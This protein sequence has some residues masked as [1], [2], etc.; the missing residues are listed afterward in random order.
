MAKPRKSLKQVKAVPNSDVVETP[1][2]EELSAVVTETKTDTNT[3]TDDALDQE[4]VD[5]IRRQSNL[6]LYGKEE[7]SEYDRILVRLKERSQ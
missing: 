1:I 3:Q 5:Y 2:Q 7:P 4:A 6:S